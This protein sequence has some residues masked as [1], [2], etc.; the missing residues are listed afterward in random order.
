MKKFNNSL[1][2]QYTESFI[3]YFEEYKVKKLLKRSDYKEILQKIA[4]IKNKY[5]QIRKIL[6][7]FEIIDI[8]DKEKEMILEILNLEEELRTIELKE[9]FKLGLK[10][11]YIYFDEMDMFNF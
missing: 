6:E 10:E 7:D 2:N 11:A 9:A 1:F 5:P 4:N 8:T 3:E